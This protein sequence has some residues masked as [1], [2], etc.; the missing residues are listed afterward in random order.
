MENVTI[1]LLDSML[2]I[3]NT[4]NGIVV[5]SSAYKTANSFIKSIYFA[6]TQVMY[7]LHDN[8]NAILIY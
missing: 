2:I 1:F 5:R 8:K 6:L 7:K 3:S 4:L